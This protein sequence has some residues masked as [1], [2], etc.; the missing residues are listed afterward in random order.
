MR[1]EELPF[2]T[3]LSEKASLRR[4]LLHRDPQEVEGK[5]KLLSGGENVLGRGA[6]QCKRPEASAYL[7]CLQNEEAGFGGK[8]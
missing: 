4:G 2:C 6:S 3:E 8:K 7:L 1:Q 5:A